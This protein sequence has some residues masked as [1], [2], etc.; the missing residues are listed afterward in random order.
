M[1][2]DVDD[3]AGRDEEHGDREG[4]PAAD[5]KRQTVLRRRGRRPADGAERRARVQA[6]LDDLTSARVPFSMGDLA[7]RAGISRATLY[8]DADLRALIGGAGDGPVNR[9]VD[10]RRYDKL[11]RELAGA[12]EERKLLRRELRK[13]ESRLRAAEKRIA[14]LA[15]EA[16]DHEKARRT[17][18]ATARNSN[19]ET[20]RAEAYAEG[21]NAGVRAAVGPRGGAANTSSGGR[22]GGASGAAAANAGL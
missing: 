16:V 7:E 15:D 13:A 8:R 3:Q 17:A 18:E 1:P 2:K 5:T 4:A 22:S 6:A 10:S 21:F 14:E 11:T 12:H 20:I 19:S 9:P